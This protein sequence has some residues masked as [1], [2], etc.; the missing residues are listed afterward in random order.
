MAGSAHGDR[1]GRL[2]TRGNH[3]PLAVLPPGVSEQPGREAL[4]AALGDRQRNLFTLVA[5]VAVVG[6]AAS[7]DSAVAYYGA[8]LTVFSIWMGWFVLTA[9]DWLRRADF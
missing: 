1:D 7:L 6:V 4:W 2:P 8:G 5:V 9:I 3:N